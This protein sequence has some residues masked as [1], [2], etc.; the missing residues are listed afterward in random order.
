M[1]TDS[2]PQPVKIDADGWYADGAVRLLFE[3]PSATLCRARRTGGLRFARRGQKIWY[4]G[5]WLIDWLER[6]KAQAA[7][8]VR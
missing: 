4:R 5:Q 2:H 3:M 6:G 1:Q 8:D 7:R